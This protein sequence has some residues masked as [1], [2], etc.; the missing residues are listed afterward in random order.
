MVWVGYWQQDAA[1]LASVL[2]VTVMGV[3]A[4][5]SVFVAE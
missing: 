2:R 5:D 1:P 4:T 3:N